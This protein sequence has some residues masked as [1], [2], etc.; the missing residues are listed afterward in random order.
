VSRAKRRATRT[1]AARS[2]HARTALWKR[3]GVQSKARG[4]VGGGHL[5]TRPHSSSWANACAVGWSMAWAGRCGISSAPKRSEHGAERL[6]C[7]S[8]SVASVLAC[9]AIHDITAAGGRLRRDMRST[10][11]RL[12]PRT[13]NRPILRLPPPQHSAY[14]FVGPIYSWATVCSATAW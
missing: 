2:C 4:R 14:G 1:R 11:S 8:P 5:G 9:H 12:S 6:R 3:L 13:S 7:P 10:S